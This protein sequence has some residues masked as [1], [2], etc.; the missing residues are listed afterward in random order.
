MGTFAELLF[1]ACFLTGIFVSLAI[2]AFLIAHVIVL[3]VRNFKPNF[4]RYEYP[5]TAKEKDEAPLNMKKTALD[6]LF[7]HNRKVRQ[8]VHDARLQ[9]LDPE[10][11]VK[12]VK[13][14]A[15]EEKSEWTLDAIKSAA[16]TLTV[17][18]DEQRDLWCLAI[19]PRGLK[20]PNYLISKQSVKGRGLRVAF[21]PLRDRRLTMDFASAQRWS[22]MLPNTV[23]LPANVWARVILRKD[24]QR[25]FA[26][27]IAECNE[28]VADLT[29]L[30]GNSSNPSEEL[31]H[32]A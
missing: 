32:E 26:A 4:C 13:R 9:K 1:S 3:F 22:A 24:R 18:K 7:E 25:D 23:I 16:K 11:M 29:K 30:A 6:F 8:A 12:L 2:F 10:T 27:E 5:V 14:V 17:Q 19:F 21:A 20:H 28:Q 15:A 31:R